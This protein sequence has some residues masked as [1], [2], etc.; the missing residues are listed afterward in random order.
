MTK[1]LENN[2][3]RLFVLFVFLLCVA[4]SFLSMWVIQ[5]AP[6]FVAVIAVIVLSPLYL[7]TG[8]LFLMVLSQD[9]FK[10]MFSEDESK[11]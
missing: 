9:T 10:D 2:N 4:V 3:S 11:Q 1:F 6:L 8:I 7:S 5:S